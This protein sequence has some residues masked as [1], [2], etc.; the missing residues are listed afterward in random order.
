MACAHGFH[1]T[2]CLLIFF[3]VRS[4]RGA[5]VRGY[6][7]GLPSDTHI[8]GTRRGRTNCKRRNP[9]IFVRAEKPEDTAT[10]AT[11]TPDWH[12]SV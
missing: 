12:E 8:P 11:G 9:V 5:A 10:M 4:P 2:R 7:W 6:Q 1:S 3:T